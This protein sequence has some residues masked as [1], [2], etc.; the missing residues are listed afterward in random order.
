MKIKCCFVS[1]P[2]NQRKPYEKI[3]ETNNS[4]C[5]HIAALVLAKLCLSAL[6]FRCGQQYQT[7]SGRDQVHQP[8]CYF[9]P[10]D[11]KSIHGTT[12]NASGGHEQA[13]HLEGSVL[14]TSDFLTSAVL[15][16]SA[17]HYTWYHACEG[18]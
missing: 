9:S 11:K 6:S 3:H 14:K 12:G 2:A 5:L 13:F 18:L 15:G 4:P 1:T 7:P 10:G 17:Y 8:Y 16:H